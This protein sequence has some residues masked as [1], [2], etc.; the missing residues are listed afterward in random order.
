MRARMLADSLTEFFDLFMFHRIVI[1][2]KA[3]SGAG[4]SYDSEGWP[5]GYL[6]IGI[7]TADFNISTLRNEISC[8]V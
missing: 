3:R 1:V 7:Y 8:A 2:S 5:W 6:K 4:G